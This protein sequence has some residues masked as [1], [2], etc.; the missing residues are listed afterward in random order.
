MLSKAVP[1][2]SVEYVKL[3]QLISFITIVTTAQN[4][5][6]LIFSELQFWGGA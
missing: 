2:Q 4:F 6:D 5:A 1:P 3:G